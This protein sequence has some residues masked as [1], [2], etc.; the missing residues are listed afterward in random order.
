MGP[1]GAVLA[2]WSFRD[3]NKC[4]N[5]RLT[6]VRF[7]QCYIPELAQTSHAQ[8]FVNAFLPVHLEQASFVYS[9][10]VKE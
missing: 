10:S 9:Q 7:V 8:S 6:S 1:T 3:K 2:L 5:I 4:K